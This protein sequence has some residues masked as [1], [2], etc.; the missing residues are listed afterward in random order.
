M[1]V[2]LINGSPRK[3]GNTFTAL[4]QVADALNAEGVETEI[5]HIGT[6]PIQG[7][8]ACMRCKTIGRC[9]FKDDLYNNLREKIE[10]ADAYVIGCPVYYAGPNGALCAILD[11]LFF[12]SRVANGYEYLLEQGV[13]CI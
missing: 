10:T 2:L 11:R 5:L 7:C 8:T 9:V 6:A 1:K 12:S 4:S 13:F 3:N